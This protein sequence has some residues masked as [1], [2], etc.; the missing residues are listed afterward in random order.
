MHIK[1]P[2]MAYLD[3]PGLEMDRTGGMSGSVTTLMCTSCVSLSGYALRGTLLGRV[4]MCQ[5][6]KESKTS[7]APMCAIVLSASCHSSTHAMHQGNCF[8]KYI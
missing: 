2:P 4:K 7:L 8:D 3:I 5:K 6:S 1:H